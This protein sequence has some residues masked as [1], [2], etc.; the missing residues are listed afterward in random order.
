[1][2]IAGD[3]GDE[4]FCNDV[5]RQAGQAFPSIDILVNNAGER[6]RATGD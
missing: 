3:V 2:L 6:A 5:I 1:M 4:A